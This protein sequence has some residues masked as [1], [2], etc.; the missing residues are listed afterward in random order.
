M[1]AHEQ[2]RFNMAC[3]FGLEMTDYEPWD[4]LPQERRDE[5]ISEARAAALALLEA[6]PGMLYRHT[7]NDP[8][9]DR[10]AIILPLM[11]TDNDQP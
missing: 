3:A 6:W 10:P 4:D 1:A 11:E 7:P 5:L 2:W 9:G 8:R